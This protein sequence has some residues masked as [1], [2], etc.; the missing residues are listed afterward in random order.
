MRKTFKYKGCEVS[1]SVQGEGKPVM[2]VHGFAEDGHIWDEQ[3]E[4]LKTHCQVLVPD[5]P[6]SG[7]SGYNEQLNTV[8]DYADCLYALLQQENLGQ[9]TMLAHSMGGYITLAFAEKYAES[10]SAFGFVHSTAFADNGEKKQNRLKG[11]KMIEECGSYDFIKNSMPNLFSIR[12]RELFA[13]KIDTLIKKGS[14]FKKEALKQYYNAMMKRP[15]RTH[16]LYNNPLPVL[17]IAGTED[18]AAP[19]HDILQQVYLPQQAWFHI[20]KNTGHMG[21]WE[22]TEAV[23]TYVLQFI[24]ETE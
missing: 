21:M 11:I 18:V 5:L 8:E 2:F 23:N 12:Y 17:Y 22:A 20:L 19:L 10:L 9:C 4:F 14:N 15:D 13:D 7:E 3:A 24:G 16:V 1:Y 6:G